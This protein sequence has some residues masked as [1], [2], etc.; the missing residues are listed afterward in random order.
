MNT[1]LTI[2]A[3]AAE[4]ELP[5]VLMADIGGEPLLARTMERARRA[6]LVDLTAVVTSTA[7]SDD[8]VERLCKQRNWACFRGPEQDALDRLLQAAEQFQAECIVHVEAQHP[9]TDPD[10]IDRALISLCDSQ[11][12]AD[13]VSNFWP[14]RSYPRG[15]DVEV[16]LRPTLERAA[17]MDQRSGPRRRASAYILRHPELF[18][19]KG[20][21]LRRGLAW[22]RWAVGNNGDLELM[23]RIYDHFG[24][25]RFTWR[26]VLKTLDAHPD[27]SAVPATSGASG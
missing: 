22:Q 5:R 4:Q 9:L 3:C 19:L 25:D 12:P 20:I 1:V 27:W 15:L 13:Y 18:R 11:P 8:P 14:R 7:R 23:R 21:Q 10:L 2:Q 26:D 24:H 6:Y 17:R 16:F